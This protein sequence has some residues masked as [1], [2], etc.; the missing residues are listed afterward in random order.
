MCNTPLP[1]EPLYTCIPLEQIRGRMLQTIPTCLIPNI[2]KLSC[3]LYPLDAY[4]GQQSRSVGETSRWKT[5]LA[6]FHGSWSQRWPLQKCV[7]LCVMLA[8]T[9]MSGVHLVVA[10]ANDVLAIEGLA[11][12]TAAT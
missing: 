9:R 7:L 12:T 11:T 6:A 4:A 3:T 10:T 1:F 2:E 5:F 8:K